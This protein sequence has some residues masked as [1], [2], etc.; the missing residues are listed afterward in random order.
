MAQP[1][2]ALPRPPVAWIDPKTGQ[3]TQVFLQFV[4]R[5]AAGEVGPLIDAANDATAAAAGVPING[6]YANA[7][8]VRIRLT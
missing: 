5:L 7:G 2:N 6:L 3:P 8:A 4:A 1:A